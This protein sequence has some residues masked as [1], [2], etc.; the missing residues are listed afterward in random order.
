MYLFVYLVISLHTYTHRENQPNYI[1]KARPYH[2]LFTFRN[3]LGSV[4]HQPNL[5]NRNWHNSHSP[6]RPQLS[7]LS[8]ALDM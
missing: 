8:S 4:G 3:V 2:K 5:E 7:G 6:Q 1:S